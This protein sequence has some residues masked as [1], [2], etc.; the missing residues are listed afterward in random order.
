[1]NCPRMIKVRQAFEGGALRDP[2]GSA[3]E[4]LDRFGVKILRGGR[5]AIAVGSRGIANMAVVVRTVASWV[6][7]QGGEPFVVPAMGSHGGAT[8]EGQRRVLEGHGVREDAY[9]ETLEIRVL[10]PDGFQEGEREL[11]RLA[12]R[13]MPRLPVDRLDVLVV[14]RLGKDISGCGMDTNIIGRIRI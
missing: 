3:R 14:D 12:R 1:M 4:G 7:D 9:D 2:V 13:N 6:K 5:I 8:A 10:R 11:L